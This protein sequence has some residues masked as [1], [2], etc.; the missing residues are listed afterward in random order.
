MP[1]LWFMVRRRRQLARLRVLT[2]WLKRRRRS[3]CSCSIGRS[4]CSSQ[5]ED[6][7]SFHGGPGLKEIPEDAAVDTAQSLSLAWKICE[8]HAPKFALDRGDPSG[9]RFNESSLGPEVPA[10]LEQLEVAAELEQLE[11]AAELEQ[12][13]VAAEREQLEN[14]APKVATT[15]EQP[16]AVSALPDE[17]FKRSESPD[18]PLQPARPILAPEPK[19]LPAPPV[20]AARPIPPPPPSLPAMP[21]EPARAGEKVSLFQAPGQ[22]SCLLPTRPT[23]LPKAFTACQPPTFSVP[24][25]MQLAREAAEGCD[26]STLNMKCCYIL[27]AMNIMKHRNQGEQNDG[28]LRWTQLHAAASHYRRNMHDVLIFLPCLPEKEVNEYRQEIKML[29]DCIVTTPAHVSDDLFMIR[30]AEMMHE[31][32]R[33]ARIVSNDLFRQ[34]IMSSSW[35]DT[36]LTSIRVRYAFAAGTFMPQDDL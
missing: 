3:K 12:L 17:L 28:R 9:K 8:N 16:R 11:V 35:R 36:Y 33:E 5:R 24:R 23:R 4:R 2:L 13:E 22:R 26:R 10:E 20:A 25:R 34:Y 30:Y 31:Q 14:P 29:G 21:L 32:R 27:D 7:G 19:P 15:A 1:L 6:A 18:A